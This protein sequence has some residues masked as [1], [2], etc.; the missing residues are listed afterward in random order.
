MSR[1]S[2]NRKYRSGLMTASVLAMGMALSGLA[3]A[4]DVALDAIVI[5]G[6]IRI[7]EATILSYA[8][9]APGG[10]ITA[11][12]ANDALRRLQDTGL[13]ETVDLRLEGNTV[14][15]ELQEYPTINE[16][17]IEGNDLLDDDALSALLTSQPRRVYSPAIAEADAQAIMDAYRQT[18]RLSATV[19]PQ[20]IRRSDNRVDLAFE[21]TEGRVVETESIT[22]VGNRAF[23]DRRL[24]RV[25]QSTQAGFFRA[26]IS[27]DTFV[28]DRLAFDQQLLT[29]FYRDRGY[30]DFEVQ[31]V[32]SELAR[33]RDG[34]F[35]TFNIVEGQSFSFG[36][37]TAS[38]DLPEVNVEEFQAAIG[39]DEGITYSPRLVDRTISR[40]ENLATEQGLRFIRVEP[41]ITRNDEDLT[42]DVE[43]AIVRGPRVFV[44]RIDIEGNATTL[45]R[46]VRRQFDMVEGDPFDPREIRL[47]AE[48]IRAL[49]FFS[50]VDVNAREGTGSD[51][52]IV[53][54]NVEE[55]PTG[56][57]G[58]SVNYSTDVGT[59]LAV[60]FNERNWRGRGQTVGLSFD[61]T[62]GSRSLRA[63][64]VEPA[65][66]RRDLELALSVFS[67]S[68]D[69]QN[70]T[71][72][73]N[74]VGFSGALEFPVSEYGRLRPSLRIAQ[75]ELTNVPTTSS[76]ILRR[77][78]GSYDSSSIGLGYIYDTRGVGLDPTSGVLVRANAELGGLGDDQF[79]R[80]TAL[81]QG[82]T[83][84]FREEVSLRA[85]F[86][87]GSVNML[88][89]NSRVTDRFF[90]G[91][92]QMRGFDA[93]G[94][95]PRDRNSANQDALGGNQFAVARFEA[96]FPIGVPA[97]YGISG[98]VFYDVGTLWGLDDVLGTGG[99]LVDDDSYLRST[100][101]FSIFW[102]TQIGPLR[103]N[104]S[105]PVSNESYDRTRN[106]D[107]T[108]EARF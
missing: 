66:L 11:G 17:S 63:N 59:G 97:E 23:S 61:T 82:E 37:L 73:T 7:E 5:D 9:I 99:N 16:I 56:T 81:V 67:S 53:D 18:G 21:I 107:F 40:L 50:N 33:A 95:G 77:E 20:I 41:R 45:D 102:D 25:L 48:R 90:L 43:F 35:V 104:F 85:A 103:F 76:D 69:Q 79:L 68:T 93:G 39:L 91:S 30:V 78:A 100:I 98:G 57:L 87:L 71:Y 27:R 28:A 55:T 29:D 22:F 52:V 4:Q 83:T 51:Q 89:G 74:E 46:V 54:V 65:Y 106:F 101:G 62:S 75:S 26:I 47:A 13:F 10:T 72:N 38:S 36:A 6:N 96:G 49:N 92:R 24:R 15:I 86:E 64:F 42:L 58:F 19:T 80:T 12:Q 1:K 88:D 70:A 3:V 31:S 84:A 2:N 94:I 44:E 108:V 105:R 14:F 34:F 32:T 60:Q 8:G